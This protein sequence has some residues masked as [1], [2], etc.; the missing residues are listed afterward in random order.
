MP[1]GDVYENY[2]PQDVRKQYVR[3]YGWLPASLK[4]VK[5][6]KTQKG[7]HKRTLDKQPLRYFTFCAVEAIDVFLLAKANI[8]K[9]SAETGRLEGVFFCERDENDF[10]IIADLIG[11]PDQGF[12][13]DFMEIML[14]Q[15]DEDT[16]GKNLYEDEREDFEEHIRIKLKIKDTH[17]RLKKA[18]PFDI[19][20]FDVCGVMFRREPVAR[21]LKSFMKLLEWQSSAVYEDGRKCQQFTLFLTSHVDRGDTNETAISDLTIRLAENI[22]DN[23]NFRS[24]FE[25]RFGYTEASRLADENFADFFC[26]A[27]P[28]YIIHEALFRL[29]WYFEQKAVYL[30]D[31]EYKREPGKTYKMMHSVVTFRRIEGPEERLSG[32]HAA[33]YNDLIN[34]LI[35]ISFEN[36]EDVLT[37]ERLRQNLQSD[38]EDIVA[39]RDQKILD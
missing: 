23:H 20:N 26:L 6:I 21:L 37:D 28:K 7:P 19:I 11:S 31:R 1:D 22:R 16:A 3:K 30:Y 13:G 14:F 27:F 12:S 17:E 39:F 24:A 32:P 18:C 9:K 10:G 5:I 2:G 25:S 34:Q 35:G 38:V 36:I 29:G 4:Q 33:Q 15:D 8:L